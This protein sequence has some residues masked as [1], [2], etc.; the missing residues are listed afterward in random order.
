M[1]TLHPSLSIGEREG[2]LFPEERESEG[3]REGEGAR[4]SEKE[5]RERGT[6]PPRGISQPAPNRRKRGGAPP[7]RIPPAASG[8]TLLAGNSKNFGDKIRGKKRDLR[9]TCSLGDARRTLAI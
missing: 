2:R 3:E 4:E 1:E 6:P 9:D 5:E 8:R 7:R